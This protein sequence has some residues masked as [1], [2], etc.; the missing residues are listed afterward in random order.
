MI[1]NNMV[2]FERCY[3]LD[4]LA[5]SS[6]SCLPFFPPNT[7]SASSLS[8]QKKL[9]LATTAHTS[10]IHAGISKAKQCSIQMVWDTM[11]VISSPYVVG[12]ELSI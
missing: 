12:V 11:P 7:R 3:V 2:G 9:V 8:C 4:G 1:N 10:Q 6:A 5:R